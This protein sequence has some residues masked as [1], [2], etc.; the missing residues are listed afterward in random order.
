MPASYLFSLE[1]YPKSYYDVE[2]GIRW[3]GMKIRRTTTSSF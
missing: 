2:R 1:E 3:C